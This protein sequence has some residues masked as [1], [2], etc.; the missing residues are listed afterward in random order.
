MPDLP[1]AHSGLPKPIERRLI[2]P[3]AETAAGRVGASAAVRALGVLL[4]KHPRAALDMFGAALA[5]AAHAGAGEVKRKFRKKNPADDAPPEPPKLDKR[6][7]KELEKAL[8]EERRNAE[9]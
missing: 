7:L 5:Q 2:R 9:G 6:K 3:H 1:D 8:R 4:R